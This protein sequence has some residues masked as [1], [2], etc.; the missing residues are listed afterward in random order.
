MHLHSPEAHDEGWGVKG[1]SGLETAV[2]LARR[3][4][5]PPNVDL[6]T[7]IGTLP[8]SKASHPQEGFL[9]DPDRELPSVRSADFKKSRK[10]ETPQESLLEKL[11]P[12]FEVR[13]A[14][15]FAHED[16]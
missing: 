14:I 5:L 4:P 9:V 2:L 13:K 8:A 7:L 16:K 3:E 15:V 12:Y 1:P 6:K 10:I 11:R